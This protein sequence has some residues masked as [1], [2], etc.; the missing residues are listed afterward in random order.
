[1]SASIENALERSDGRGSRGTGRPIRPPGRWWCVRTLH[2][3]HLLLVLESGFSVSDLLIDLPL[4][5]GLDLGVVRQEGD[6]GQN[7]GAG[8]SDT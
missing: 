6:N 1:M 4:H 2:I 5:P 8:S 3:V 7:A